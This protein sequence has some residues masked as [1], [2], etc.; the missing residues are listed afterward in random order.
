MFNSR[1]GVEGGYRDKEVSVTASH[2]LS[3]NNTINVLQSLN[4]ELAI[5]NILAALNNSEI[6][7]KLMAQGEYDAVVSQ[8]T[9]HII[10]NA[11]NLNIHNNYIDEAKAN[12][13]YYR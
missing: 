4:N 8:V 13:T 5:S 2:G 6:K 9:K 3:E 7:S 1:E 10:L 12:R 11:V